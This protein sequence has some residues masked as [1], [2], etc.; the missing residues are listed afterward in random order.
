MTAYL[1]LRDLPLRARLTAPRYEPLPGESLMGLRPGERDTVHDLL[2]GMLLPSGNDA[3]V[4][5]ADGVA[6][7]VPAFVAKMNRA[8]VRLGLRDT[9]YA[10]PVG[11]DSPGNYSSARDLV[12]LTRVLRRNALF[13][14]IVDTRRK[15]VRSGAE[16]RHL[17][18][19]NDLLREASF[20]TGVKTGT[21]VDA[22]HV[23]VS[24]GTRHG[25]T[26]VAALLGAPTE[27][28]RDSGS[29]ALLRYGFSRYHRLVPLLAG[30]PAARVPVRFANGPLL[31][32]PATSVRLYARDDQR[33]RVRVQDPGRVTGPIPAGRRLGAARVFVDGRFD[34]A[35][36]LRAA[37]AVPAPVI[38]G[39]AGQALPGDPPRAVV[40]VVGLLAVGLGARGLGRLRTQ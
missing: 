21:T 1:V 25:V 7:S 33:V 10:T 2:Y 31:L 24:S 39:A 40:V 18:N 12:A 5:L 14:K 19:S 22:R 23:L 15:T 32:R 9:H 4:T 6:G 11:L 8:A 16:V 20:V 34:G 35:A 27:A 36:D 37:R 3:A 17:V 26:L 29:L 38:A 13:R 28:E 30:R